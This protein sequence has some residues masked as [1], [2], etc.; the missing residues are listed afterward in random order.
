[1]DDVHTQ[2]RSRGADGLAF[3]IQNAGLDG[4]GAGGGGMGYEGLHN[5]LVVEFDT[6]Y[7]PELEDPYENHV[8]VHT[9]GFR[10]SVESHHSYSL[11]SSVEV[12]DLTEG[13]H[14]VRVVYTPIFDPEVIRTGQLITSPYASHF[15][16][17][18]DF[19]NGGQPDWGTGV[20]LLYVYVDE[21]IEP[22]LV[23]PLNLEATLKLDQGR[24]WVGFTA[25]TGD[26]TWQS[27]DLISW[28]FSATREN[29]PYTPPPIV[30]G[31]GAFEC[32]PG[33]LDSGVC[34]H[35]GIL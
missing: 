17:N 3:V 29:I 9:R 21:M 24:A 30:N 16:E 19:P 2:C 8:S 28:V 6:Y 33:S 25:A 22:R 14:K 7:N 12:T 11:G 13:D 20:G 5:A 32:S 23:L 31:E 27:H 18:A 15:L 35:P 34:I 1:M 10:D 4:L 26:E